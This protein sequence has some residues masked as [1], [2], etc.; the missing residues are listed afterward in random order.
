L[1]TTTLK[2]LRFMYWC[3]SFEILNLYE[4]TPL[5]ENLSI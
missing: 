2:A 5:Y 4:K 3:S 1:N